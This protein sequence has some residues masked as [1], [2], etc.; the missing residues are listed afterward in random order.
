MRK[1]NLL[2]IMLTLVCFVTFTTC[3]KTI[4]GCMDS[5]STNYN[6]QAT[7]SDGSCLYNEFALFYRPNTSYAGSTNSV[8]VDG[9]YIGSC[10]T[11]WIGTPDCT[12]DANNGNAIY[13]G[14]AGNHSVKI[15]FFNHYGFGGKDSLVSHFTLLGSLPSISCLQLPVN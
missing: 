7:E 3:K 1:T 6:P 11:I 2:A 12:T 15:V 14:P 4:K 8:Y 13:K 10:T 9:T 5:T